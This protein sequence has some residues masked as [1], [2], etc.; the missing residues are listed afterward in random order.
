MV[1]SE[2]I[3]KSIKKNLLELLYKKQ[4]YM[5]T[6]I[7]GY[8]SFHNLFEDTLDLLKQTES[9]ENILK[10]ELSFRKENIEYLRLLSILKLRL[11][12]D[13]LT[14]REVEKTIIEMNEKDKFKDGSTINSL[15][16]LNG[17]ICVR[18]AVHYSN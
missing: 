17:I 2:D 11:Q 9:V 15:N 16:I 7:T 12:N 6:L 14:C 4:N 5:H 18:L 8:E 1:E 10:N 3:K 13:P